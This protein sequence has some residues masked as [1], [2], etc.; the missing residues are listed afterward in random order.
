MECSRLAS[1]GRPTGSS[2]VV[3]AMI[4]EAY[5]DRAPS[6]LSLRFPGCPRTRGRLRKGRA[7]RAQFPPIG[8][9]R[10][11]GGNAPQALVISRLKASFNIYD[12]FRFNS[13]CKREAYLYSATVWL[14]GWLAGCLS[15]LLRDV[16]IPRD[17]RSWLETRSFTPALDGRKTFSSSSN[18][19][20]LRILSGFTE[21]HL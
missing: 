15:L 16:L 2:L 9:R 1:L 3:I 6:P 17:L 12:L 4:R 21:L 5:L 13:T 18:L 7:H 8:V 19:N 14:V 10:S 11:E 20:A